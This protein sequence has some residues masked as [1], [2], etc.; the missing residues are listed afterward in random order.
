[1]IDG[2]SAVLV[3]RGDVELSPILG[4]L[5]RHYEDVVVWNNYDEPRDVS[6]FGRY[7]AT[8][9]CKNDL[10]YFQDDD[11]V[12]TKHEELKAAWDRKFHWVT[13]DG[14]PAHHS[15]MLCNMDPAWVE[16]GGYEDVGLLGMGGL[17]PRYGWEYP[18]T[19]Y[20]SYYPE[21][22][23]FLDWCDFVT[24][25]LMGHAKIDLGYEVRDVAHSGKRLA[26]YPANRARKNAMIERARRLRR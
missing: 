16:R 14:V 26:H 24:G 25:V 19:E 21:D 13:D 4:E 10:V 11:I 9:R 2:V 12:F 20:L 6:V 5:H 17:M 8:E 7:M 1:M 3:T 18:I 23:F 22:K 15:F